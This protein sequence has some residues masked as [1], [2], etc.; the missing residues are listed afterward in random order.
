MTWLTI[1]EKWYLIKRIHEDNVVLSLRLQKYFDA[2]TKEINDKTP[3]PE[4]LK[5]L[6]KK[7]QELKKYLKVF[8]YNL[9]LLPFVIDGEVKE[10]EIAFTKDRINMVNRSIRNINQIIKDSSNK[11]QR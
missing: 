5:I 9:S 11:T 1:D 7:K 4:T 2:Q 8:K 6:N 3:L 10:N